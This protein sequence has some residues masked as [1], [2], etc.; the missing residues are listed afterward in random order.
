MRRPRPDLQMPADGA[1][2]FPV[3]A[4]GGGWRMSRMHPDDDEYADWLRELQDEQRGP[5]LLERGVKFWLAGV[6]LFLGAIG[7]A[8]LIAL[9]THAFV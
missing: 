5:G 4:D 2:L 8:M 7:G 9:L 1:I 3:K 6:L